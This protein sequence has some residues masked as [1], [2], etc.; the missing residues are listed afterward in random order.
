MRYLLILALTLCLAPELIA[1]KKFIPEGRDP[2]P[3]TTQASLKTLLGSLDPLSISQ[4]LAFYELYPGTPEGKLALNRAWEL[5]GTQ[6]LASA[7]AIT[8]LPPSDVQGIISLVTRQSFDPPVKLTEEQL[9]VIETIAG[10]LHN[11]K[12]KGH[13]IWSRT[14][15]LALSNE[16]TD[17]A[18][19]LLLFQFE[20]SADLK[21]EIRQYEAGLDLMALQIQARLSKE[22]THEEKIREINHFIFQEMQF[23]FPPHCDIGHRCG[24]AA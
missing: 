4:H 15:V 20:E 10:R 24:Q 8:T 14:D 18:R 2:P 3:K 19:S 6:D 21:N 5:L 11:R 22:A 16:E 12:L 17:L 1:K 23:R 13:A 9:Q 7:A